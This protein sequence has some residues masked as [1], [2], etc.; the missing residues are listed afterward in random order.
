MFLA[1]VPACRDM[2]IRQRSIPRENLMQTWN[3][4]LPRTSGHD[5]CLLDCP[6]RHG[7]GPLRQD[8]IASEEIP[9]CE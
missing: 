3:L 5:A 1:V 6:D 2:V 7:G 9:G 8:F 4:Q